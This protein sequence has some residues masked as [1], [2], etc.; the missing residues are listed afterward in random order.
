MV[1][2]LG[3]NVQFFSVTGYR[4][5]GKFISRIHKE[6]QVK[7]VEEMKGSQYQKQF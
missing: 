4:N 3:K 6:L 5:K 1:C 2:Q 7:A